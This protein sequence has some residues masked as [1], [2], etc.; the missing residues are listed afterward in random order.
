MET[1][2]DAGVGDVAEA[3]GVGLDERD[4][5]VQALGCCVGDAVALS[6]AQFLSRSVQKQGPPV[7]LSYLNGVLHRDFDGKSCQHRV[8]S[9]FGATSR[10]VTSLEE[11]ADVLLD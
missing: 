7:D 3:P 1:N 2:G 11:E 10:K 9:L 4:C 8:K 5:V 6:K